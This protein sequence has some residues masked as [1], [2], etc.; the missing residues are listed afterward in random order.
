VIADKGEFLWL[1]PMSLEPSQNPRRTPYPP[2]RFAE[3]VQSVRAR[4]ILQPLNVRRRGSGYQV[5][6]GDN[7]RLA[8]IEAQLEAVPCLSREL[9]DLD[10][11]EIQLIENIQRHDM[12]PIDEGLAFAQLIAS[13]QHTV[14]SIASK[15]GKSIR[16]VYQRLEFTKLIPEATAAFLDGS[17]TASHAERLTRHNAENQRLILEDGCFE[18]SLVGDPAE[19][20]LVS[21]YSLDLWIAEHIVLDVDVPALAQQLPEIG[22]ARAAVEA[23]GAKLLQVSASYNSHG[24]PVGVLGRMEWKKATGQEKCTLSERAVIVKGDGQGQVITVCRNRSC[25]KH[26]PTDAVARSTSTRAASSPAK[27]LSPKASAAEERAREKHKKWQADQARQAEQ[28]RRRSALIKASRRKLLAHLVGLEKI[29][30][31]LVQRG[32]A[33]AFRFNPTL[34]EVKGALGQEPA[35]DLPRALAVSIVLGILDTNDFMLAA[36]A[37]KFDL[38]PF[39]PKTD[40]PAKAP[41]ATKA[42]GRRKGKARG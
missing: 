27:P 17:L 19:L 23:D 42:A 21:V 30:P 12:H 35:K 13:K 41:K 3:L 34:R 25:P 2:A 5:V 16:W 39:Q 36:K 14:E 6:T 15:V 28:E 11:L 37:S 7:R 10:V 9:S 20:V 24:N 29:P 4:G 8:A 26:W 1:D 18:R 33:K 38:T 40:A 32:L 22:E 31:A